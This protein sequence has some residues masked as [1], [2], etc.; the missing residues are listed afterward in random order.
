MANKLVFRY[1][2]AS[3]RQCEQY[4]RDSVAASV[5]YISIVLFE[6][7]CSNDVAGL[8]FICDS[9]SNGLLICKGRRRC[10]LC[11]QIV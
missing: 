4:G 10:R 2:A 1:K 6:L 3:R 8:R 9:R 5:A 11:S 7:R